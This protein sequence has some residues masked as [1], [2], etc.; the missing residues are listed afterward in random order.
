MTFSYWKRLCISYKTSRWRCGNRMMIACLLLLLLAIWILEHRR[1]FWAF[2]RWLVLRGPWGRNTLN[3]INFEIISMARNDCDGKAP[4]LL[5]FLQH[6]WKKNCLHKVPL[7][8][9]SARR[10]PRQSKLTLQPSIACN[11]RTFFQ[12]RQENNRKRRE[13]SSNI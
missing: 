3:E 9:L 11:R 10:L 13:K 12:L 5:L 6:W 4:M 2:S 1:S 7:E 8:T